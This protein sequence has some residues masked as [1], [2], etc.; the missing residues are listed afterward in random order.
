MNAK[1]HQYIR[2]FLRNL[3][4]DNYVAA[5]EDLRSC[6]VEKMRGRMKEYE[7]SVRERHGGKPCWSGESVK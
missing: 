2:G 5:R 3:A 7:N 4:E 6:L 1:E